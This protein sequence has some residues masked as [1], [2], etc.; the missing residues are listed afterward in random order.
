MNLVPFFTGRPGMFNMKDRAKWDSWKAVEGSENHLTD[1]LV[2]V[3]SFGA[4]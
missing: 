4:S 3:A 2:F 1:M